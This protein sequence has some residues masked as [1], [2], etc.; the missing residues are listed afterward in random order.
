MVSLNLCPVCAFPVFSDSTLK[1]NTSNAGGGGERVL[2]TAVA[3]L[4]RT[5]P[6]V[7]SVVY[8][9]DVD[10]TKE[11]II[12]KVKVGPFRSSLVF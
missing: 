1:D 9:G 6:D 11:E 5:E 10:A 8:S 3:G 4:Q 7:V 12:E 2:W